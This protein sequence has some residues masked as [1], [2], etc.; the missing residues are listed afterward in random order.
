M[1]RKRRVKSGMFSSRTALAALLALGVVGGAVITPVPAEAAKKKK[2]KAPKLSFSKGFV[3]V[4]APAQ[5][6]ID[7]IAEGDA[8]SASAARAALAQAVSAIESE[9]D[10]YMAG[11]LTVKMGNQTKDAAQQR[12]GLK[13]MLASGKTNPSNAPRLN[14]AAGDMAFRAQDYKEAQHYLQQAVDGGYPDAGVTVMLGESFI[15]DNQVSKG[16]G[17]LKDAIAGQK[18]TGQIAPESWYKR[19]M[20]SAFRVRMI[21]EASEF[22]NLLVTD[23]PSPKN[24]GLAVTIIRELGNFGSQETLDLM[25]LMG[26]TNSYTEQRDY[27]EYIQAADPRRL[28]GETMDVINAGLASGK[29]NSSDAFVA[30]ARA[31]ASGRI[32]SDKASLSGYARDARKPGSKAATVSGAADALLSYGENAA[33]EELFTI[34][35]TKPGIDIN[36]SLTR[37]GIAQVA[38]GKYGQAQTTFAKVTGIRSPISKL[39]SAYASSKA[40]PTPAAATVTAAE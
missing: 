7:A 29:L 31:Q 37:L 27:V 5:Q 14:A 35:L 19:G 40:T 33:A 10:R 12:A 4:A 39:W 15:A 16:V 23:Y 34:A 26:R 24:V 25:R 1:D 21:S 11:S 36:Q 9:D 18:A 6:A 3:A 2:S 20:A 22:G 28:P 30:D 38:Q 8:A 17:I 13:M 32:A